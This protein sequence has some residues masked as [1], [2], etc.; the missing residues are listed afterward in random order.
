VDDPL[1]RIDPS[2]P[3]VETARLPGAPDD[4]TETGDPVG[5]VVTEEK[6]DL[7]PPAEEKEKD[8]LKPPAK[9]K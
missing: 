4:K 1:S 2:P 6:D 8:D 3:L 5:P 7:K 9:E